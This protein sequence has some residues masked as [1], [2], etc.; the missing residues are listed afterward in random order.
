MKGTK[1]QLDT[2]LRSLAN[3]L[4]YRVGYGIGCIYLDQ[5]PCKRQYRIVKKTDRGIESS[6]F[7]NEV[8]TV[9]ELFSAICFAERAIQLDRLNG[10]DSSQY[11]PSNKCDVN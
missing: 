10:A 8:Y 2:K 11:Y 1:K 9:A 3:I 5:V 7:G 6:I 4:G